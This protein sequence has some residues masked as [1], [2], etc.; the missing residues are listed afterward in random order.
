MWL[1]HKINKYNI[2]RE[3]ESPTP[4]IY[5]RQ[6]CRGNLTKWRVFLQ[7]VDVSRPLRVLQ[8][9]VNVSHSWWVLHQVVDAASRPLRVL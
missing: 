8:Q 4:L 9:A 6:R 5:V 7:V 2:F 1:S 3:K